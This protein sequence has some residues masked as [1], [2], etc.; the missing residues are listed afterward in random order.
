MLFL[1][2]ALLSAAP[3]YASSERVRGEVVTQNASKASYLG[4]QFVQPFAVNVPQLSF[5]GVSQDRIEFAKSANVKNRAKAT[6]VGII[7]RADTELISG[8]IGGWRNAGGGGR[9][10]H[11]KVSSPNAVSMRL[12]LRLES[13]DPRA[14]LRVSGPGGFVYVS[15]AADVFRSTGEDGTVWTA[16]TD[17]D[18]QLV[19]LYLPPSAAGLPVV[20]VEAAIHDFAS[21]RD[22]FKSAI[23]PKGASGSCNV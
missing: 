21:V 22:G 4:E 3:T 13:L 23:Q 5:A 11:F 10:N 9:I 16:I 15:S 12:Q 6:Q 19:E 8:E 18:I 14:E 7:Q 2:V 20:K 1:L 17:G